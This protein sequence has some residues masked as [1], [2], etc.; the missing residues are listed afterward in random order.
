M[1]KPSRRVGNK[2][3]KRETMKTNKELK[4]C[5]F[6][7]D[8]DVQVMEWNDDVF[9]HSIYCTSV[10]CIGNACQEQ[11]HKTLKEAI[12]AWN[13]RQE[14][15]GWIRFKEIPPKK[16]PAFF[17]TGGLELVGWVDDKGKCLVRMNMSTVEIEPAY[18]MQPEPPKE[19]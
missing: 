6:C 2:Q 11:P 10:F 17:S 12:E 9:S 5:P 7:G 4:A 13:Q 8:K 3:P 14:P 15:Q 18:W 16:G 19:Q 1:D